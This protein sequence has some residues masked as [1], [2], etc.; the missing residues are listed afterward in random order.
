MASLSSI[1]GLSSGLNTTQIVDTLIQLQRRPALLLE[2]EQTNKTNIV[3]SLNAIQAKIIALASEARQLARR[4]TW[5]TASIDVSDETVLKAVPNGRVAIGS[6]DI[7]VLSLARNHQLASQGYSDQSAAS[8]GTGTLV[9]SVG[10]G[11]AKTITVDAN[12]N[13]LVGIKKAINDAKAGVTASIVNDGTNSR[14]Y[15]LILTADKTGVANKINV[16]SDLAGPNNLNFSTASFDV[17]ETILKN[18]NTTSVVSLASTASYTGTSN[19]TYTFTVGGTGSQT[20]GGAPITVDW[21]DGT[22]SGSALVSQADNTVTIAGAGSEGLKL[23][24]SAGNLTAGDTFQV[25]TFAPILQHAADAKISVGSTG[26]GGSPIVITSQTNTFGEAVGGLALTV[27]RETLSN[28]SVNVTTAV[29]LDG[30]KKKVES[31][32]KAYNDVMKFIDDQNTY[33]KETKESGTLFG[34]YTLQSVQH[35]IRNSLANRVAGLKGKY[36]QLNSVGIRTLANGQLSL[37]EPARLDEAL[38][39][40]LDE[41]IKLFADSG[42]TSTA[43]VEY[44]S[45][46][47]ET[48]SGENYSV[49]ITTAATKGLF[50]G[51]SIVSPASSALTLT[52]ANNRLKFSINGIESNE[53]VLTEKTYTSTSELI[54]ELQDKINADEKIGTRGLTVSWVSTGETT[55]Y[56]K[57]ESSTYG[58]SSK[59]NLVTSI[60]NSGFTTLGLS[61]GTSLQGQDVAGTING[62][63]ADGSGQIL[64][65]REKNKTT[66]GLKVRVLMTPEELIDGNESAVTISRGVSARMGDMLDSLTRTGSG[67]LD[68]RIKSYEN[69]ITNIKTQITEIDKRL[70]TRRNDLLKRFQDMEEVLGQ[71]NAES[72]FL[73]GQIANLSNNF[74]RPGQRTR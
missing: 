62:E 10:S 56:I 54:T 1:D 25:Q 49:N 65:G 31:F 46:T 12:N 48:K 35:S 50:N 6:Y 32:I 28:D 16:T 40:N 39:T 70:A 63:A 27:R 43:S 17:P 69:Q 4:T 60:A 44:V 36:T 21:S 59:V 19:K 15:R 37:R 72:T 33:K 29:D 20:V 2:Q 41:V 34:D 51:T 74:I 14:G 8:L 13:S 7:R 9:I 53:L 71:L 57:L 47:A 11:S 42:S 68:R 52:N 58:N 30:M 67:I 64:T 45:S 55:G 24:F 23:S 26:N 38:Q 3:T 5:E 18:A 66:S 61:T 22:N 73:S